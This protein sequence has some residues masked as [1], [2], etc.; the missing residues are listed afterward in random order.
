MGTREV[1]Q[2]AQ[3]QGG[4]L[5]AGWVPSISCE[6]GLRPP[7]VS[8]PGAVP[9]PSL[10][11]SPEKALLCSWAPQRSSS[12]LGLC[13]RKSSP[14]IGSCHRAGVPCSQLP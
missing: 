2:S 13:F 6:I 9:G 8:H 4:E 11:K 12:H 10:K 1:K 7:P 3:E 14:P 5:G